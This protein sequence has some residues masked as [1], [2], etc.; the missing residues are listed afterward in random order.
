MSVYR[1]KTKG[2]F[3]FEFDRRIAGQR[4]RA[5]KCLPRSWNQ[6][7]ADAFDRKESARL[8]A[9]ARGIEKPDHTIEDAVAAYLK[10]RVPQ[11]KQGENVARELALIYWAY[12]G[13]PLTALPD[14][15]KAYALK[16]NGL[17]P[18]T[19]RNRIR[20]LTAACRW[21]WKHEGMGDHDPAARVTV[22]EVKNERQ[23]YITRAEMLKLARGCRN[24]DA[25]KAVR[26]AFY[27]GMRL[28][29][30]L[31][32]RRVRETFVLDDSKN[33]NPRIIP[34]HP[35]IRSIC[36]AGAKKIT[37]Q[38]AF[39]ESARAQGMGQY[40]FH[41]LRHSAASEMINAGADLYTVGAVLGHK[42]TRSTQ[43][44]AHLATGSLA[45]AIG[46]IGKRV[47]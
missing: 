21:A 12:Q 40:H 37:I 31:R 11:L 42:D 22:P 8:Y 33:G 1:D 27:S 14:V 36:L 32:A 46:K 4:V 47:A 19:I 15:C 34:V 2:C 23:F 39:K 7:Q 20:Y 3:I 9:L 30:I 44:Y 13:R 38:Q 26:I 25:R 43:R 17:S 18:A 5:R 16:N 28:A 6:A 10:G 29:E 35:R 45:V 41:D 24:L